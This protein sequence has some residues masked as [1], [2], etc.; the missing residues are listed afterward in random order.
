MHT[1]KV[2]CINLKLCSA[3]RLVKTMILNEFKKTKEQ[4]LKDLMYIQHLIFSCQV[5]I[6]YQNES[7]M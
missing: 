5:G 6:T 2:L 4:S 7:G 1:S 3:A